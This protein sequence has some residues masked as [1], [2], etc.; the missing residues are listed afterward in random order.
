MF[1]TLYLKLDGAVPSRVAAGLWRLIAIFSM[2]GF[3][4]RPI[5]L[6]MLFLFSDL[7]NAV[8]VGDVVMIVGAV[9]G[10]KRLILETVD[11]LVSSAYFSDL[12]GA[13]LRW[14]RRPHKMLIAEDPKHVEI[15]VN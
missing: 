6:N 9:A 5:D 14:G 15:S 12:E 4:D 7:S 2:D 8:V 11:V 3:C 13:E 10:N 1:A